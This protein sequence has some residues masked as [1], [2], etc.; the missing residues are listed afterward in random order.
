ML[1]LHQLY[2]KKIFVPFLLLF[3]VVGGVVFYTIKDIYISQIK[4]ELTSDAKLL[5]FEINDKTDYDNLVK[6]VKKA[7]N[8]RVTI[9]RDDGLVLAESNRDK[10]KM[11]NHKF[12]PEI[13]EARKKG[14]GSSIRHSH[15]LDKDLIYVANKVSTKKGIIFVRVAKKIKK[16]DEDILF[17]ALKIGGILI[18]FFAVVFFN[19]YK[20]GE[21]LSKEVEKISKFL[22]GLTKK[23]K[24][25]YIT[26]N[27]SKEFYD[28]T[29]LLTKVASIL[30]KRDKQKAKYTRKLKIA[31]EQKDD[32][33][34]AISH[35]F[36][37]PITVINGYSETLLEDEDINR[38]IKRRFL[39]KINAN[40]KRLSSLIDTLRLSVKLD[41]DKMKLNFEECNLYNLSSEVI[42]NLEQTYK[43]RVIELK[44]DRDVN[45]EADRLLFS[46]ALTNLIENALKYSEERVTVSIEKNS[47]TVKDSGVG[48]EEKELKN[49]TK[50]FYRISQNSWNNSLGLGLSIVSNILNLHNFKLEIK[51]KKNEGSE[52][53]IVFS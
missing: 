23:K 28:I 11:D 17:L 24:G 21:R 27:L 41:S 53:S 29:R 4:D 9:I 14:L 25:T 38:D 31:N 16:I 40:G 39:Q 33:I 47:I 30:E 20:I 45:V 18:L 3:F 19:I 35:E 50:K 48:I 32:I 42:D 36:K 49:I 7:L 2:F 52:F 6:R 1:K 43:D 34:S 10:A 5:A 8:I 37:N 51:S 15:T 26:S 12:R 13:V 22:I 44:G 46:V